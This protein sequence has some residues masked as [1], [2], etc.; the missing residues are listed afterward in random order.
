MTRRPLFRLSKRSLRRG[1]QRGQSLVEFSLIVPLIMTMTLS[2]AE[3]GMAYGTN[4]T[5][6]QAT[7]EGARVGAILVAGTSPLVCPGVVGANEVDPQIIL[8][9][10]QVVESP[11]SGITPANIEWIHI[12]KSNAIGGEVLVN[13]WKPGSGSACGGSIHLDFSQGT[14]GWPAS[15]RSN[16]L[17]VESI[18]VSIRYRY[19]LFTPLSALT[20]LFG[21][22]QITMV[23]S[24]VMALEP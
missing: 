4:M 22:S 19:R 20:G 13:E 11:G 3:F 15:T 9:V 21:V 24:T 14:I 17:P 18:G 10:Q 23:D 7:R 8:A 2:I 16:A 5:M 1:L 12:Y 6:I